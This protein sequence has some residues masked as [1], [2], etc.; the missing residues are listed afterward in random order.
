MRVYED[1]EPRRLNSVPH[2]IQRIVIETLPNALG[3]HN[4]AS[5]VRELFELLDGLDDGGY[6]YFWNKRKKAEAVERPQTREC[7]DSGGSRAILF[8]VIVQFLSQSLSPSS[9]QEVEPW[10]S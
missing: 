8:K 5:D 9:W 1:D 4:H 6:L 7:F 10:I 2:W 3:S